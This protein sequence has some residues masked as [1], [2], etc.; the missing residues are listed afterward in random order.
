MTLKFMSAM[1]WAPSP[2][3][4]TIMTKNSTLMQDIQTAIVMNANAAVQMYTDSTA[5][6]ELAS[7]ESIPLQ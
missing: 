5:M 6:F 2:L 1:D 3:L 4:H 7:V